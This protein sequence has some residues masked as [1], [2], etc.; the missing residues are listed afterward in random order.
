M[1]T[2]LVVVAIAFTVAFLREAVRV[3]RWRQRQYQV[4]LR[5]A[6]LESQ[7]GRKKGDLT[8]SLPSLS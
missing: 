4:Q 2:T 1:V 3:Y 5:L 8:D 7:N 6:E